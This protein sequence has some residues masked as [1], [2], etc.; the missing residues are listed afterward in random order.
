MHTN[1]M[2][3][4]SSICHR[5]LK[6]FFCRADNGPCWD[7]EPW[8]ALTP[9]RAVEHM[10]ARTLCHPTPVK[11]TGR[12]GRLS[13]AWCGVMRRQRRTRP[14]NGSVEFP[15]SCSFSLW[16]R[17]EPVASPGL[18]QTSG[19]CCSNYEGELGIDWLLKIPSI[20]SSF[21]IALMNLVLFLKLHRPWLSCHV[22]RSMRTTENDLFLHLCDIKTSYFISSSSVLGRGAPA[23]DIEALNCELR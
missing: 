1:W 20:Y 17:A 18:L 15:S 6:T 11:C 21:Q 22:S 14:C 16:P 23:E 2:T 3:N 4:Y 5:W 19:I 12:L 13:E 10:L 8:S 9:S 7:R